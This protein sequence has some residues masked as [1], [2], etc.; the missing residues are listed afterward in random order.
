MGTCG[1]LVPFIV[2]AT[3]AWLPLSAEEL[4][5]ARFKSD[6]ADNTYEVGAK[7]VVEATVT[8]AFGNAATNGVVEIWAD[9][10]WTNVL[11]RQ[12]LDLAKEQTVKGV[13]SRDTPGSVRFHA[14]GL[15][16]ARYHDIDR[17][18]FGVGGIRPLTPCPGDFEEYWLGEQKRLDREIAFNV[19][20]TLAPDF[21][22][23]GRKA[24]RVSFPTFNGKRV[25]GILAIPD[26]EGPFPVLVNI[27]GAG[28]GWSVLRREIVRK[29]WITLMMNIHEYPISAD[30]QEQA[31]RYRKHLAR[32][33]KESGEPKYQRYGWG[34]GRREAPI[35]HDMALGMVRAVEWLA[36]EPYADSSRFVYNGV[37][38]GGGM[39]IILTALYGKFAKSAIYCPSMCDMLAYKYGREPG[40][41]NIIDQT[42]AHRPPAEKV[43]PY[44][45]AC[46][47]ARLV[48]TPIRMA[49]GTRDNNCNTVAGIAA[50]N[51]LGSNDKALVILPDK[52]HPVW[53][54]DEATISKWLFDLEGR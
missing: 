8:D 51:S 9:D 50:F 28:P 17:V 7:A 13:F 42:D 31:A 48:K 30:E 16:F 24:Y 20:K 25:H 18:I 2:F 14:K 15:K 39:G 47:F 1:L 5:H 33:S 34:T 54:K 44:Y 29:G 23:A 21:S 10:G 26:G 38:Q 46:N 6:S 49:H 45:D 19:E 37:S 4:F 3:V 35:Y 41:P 27:P 52:G 36:N 22:A 40:T 43:A 32:L 53:F 12:T 11:W